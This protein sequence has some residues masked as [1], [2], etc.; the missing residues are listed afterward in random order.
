[1]PILLGPIEGAKPSP[2]DWDFHLKTGAEPASE[3]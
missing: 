2:R 1:M 3:T